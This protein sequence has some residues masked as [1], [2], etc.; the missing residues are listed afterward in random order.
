MFRLLYNLISYVHKLFPKSLQYELAHAIV[1]SSQIKMQQH[2]FIGVQAQVH[3]G[4]A[5]A[6]DEFYG[7]FCLVINMYV[8]ETSVDTQ[9][10][11]VRRPVGVF[12]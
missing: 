1:S 11:E 2:D 3:L 5:C 9:L 7:G 8:F 12:S 6:A 10:G 4:I